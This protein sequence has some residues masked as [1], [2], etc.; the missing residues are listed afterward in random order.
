MLSPPVVVCFGIVM[1]PVSHHLDPMERRVV[2]FTALISS[3]VLLAPCAYVSARNSIEWTQRPLLPD[4]Q[5]DLTGVDTHR[6]TSTESG[7]N[8]ARCIEGTAVG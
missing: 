2:V 3:V 5:L 6:R 7:K 1:F 8:Q 4:D